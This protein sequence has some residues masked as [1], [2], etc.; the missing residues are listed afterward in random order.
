[1]PDPIK[2]LKNL[3]EIAPKIKTAISLCALTVLCTF[4][5]VFYLI[6][7][8]TPPLQIIIVVLFA[9]GGF[10]AISLVIISRLPAVPPSQA[11]TEKSTLVR[12]D[13]AVHL[14]IW[15]DLVHNLGQMGFSAFERQKRFCLPDADYHFSWAE[16][17]TA[18]L[19]FVQLTPD[20][21]GVTNLRKIL[22]IM[23]IDLP[24]FAGIN[25]LT[26]FVIV[27]NTPLINDVSNSYIESLRE[28]PHCI[29][30]SSNTIKR[31][32]RRDDIAQDHM[33]AKLYPCIQC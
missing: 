22:S 17:N 29:L 8:P 6:M 30:L 9:I 14:D 15:E 7:F 11:E 12:E 25:D 27:C 33:R 31:L 4:G 18:K 26:G 32:R 10:H 3:F 13:L 1:M 21:L 20:E 2:F 28:P 16:Y 23:R 19:I 24:K 5:L